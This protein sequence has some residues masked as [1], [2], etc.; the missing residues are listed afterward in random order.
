MCQRGRTGAHNWA[1]RIRRQAGAP[2][3]QFSPVLLCNFT[4]VLT[5]T[6]A[7][8]AIGVLATDVRCPSARQQTMPAT[9]S[10]REGS[11]P[12]PRRPTVSGE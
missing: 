3:V 5:I 6:G 12:R 7:A 11:H 4:P 2:S 1:Q 9:R 10:R 8:Q